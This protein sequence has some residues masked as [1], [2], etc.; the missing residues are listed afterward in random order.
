MA[1][2]D[3]DAQDAEDAL[4]RRGITIPRDAALTRAAALQLGVAAQDMAILDVMVAGTAEEA[5]AI[6][7][8][9]AEHDELQKVVLAQQLLAKVGWGNRCNMTM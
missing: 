4:V 9:L 1:R 8:Y 2:T 3:E 5:R 7:A 6:C